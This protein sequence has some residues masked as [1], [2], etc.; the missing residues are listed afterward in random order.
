MCINSTK[1]S[2]CS[3]L[4]IAVHPSKRCNLRRCKLNRRR[5]RSSNQAKEKK[6]EFV[7]AVMEIKNMKLYMQ[8]KTIIEENEKL[9]KK[10]LLLH[11]ENQAL[12]SQ[13]QMKFSNPN[14]DCSLAH[15][16]KDSHY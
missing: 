2:P 1:S 3:P 9:R 11:Q 5:R 6:T 14:N 15:N 10:A 4:Y 13:L 7:K 12:L 16:T 8:N